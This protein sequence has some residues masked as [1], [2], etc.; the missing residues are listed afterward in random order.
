MRASMGAW[1]ENEAMIPGLPPGSTRPKVESA[2][3]MLLG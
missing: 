1:V 2:L 3:I